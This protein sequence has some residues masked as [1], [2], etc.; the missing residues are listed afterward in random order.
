MPRSTHVWHVEEAVPQV[1]Q[2]ASRLDAMSKLPSHRRRRVRPIPPPPR[3]SSLRKT[4]SKQ[5]AAIHATIVL[6]E[7]VASYD[8]HDSCES[9]PMPSPKLLR[10]D[11]NKPLPPTPIDQGYECSAAEYINKP[12]P[13]TPIERDRGLSAARIHAD[14]SYVANAPPPSP[15]EGE[16]E[17]QCI[18]ARYISRRKCRRSIKARRYVPLPGIPE[19]A[20]EYEDVIGYPRKAT[21]QPRRRLSATTVASALTNVTVQIKKHLLRTVDSDPSF[22]CI[23][24]R[25]IER[26]GE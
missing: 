14:F 21:E 11:L 18:L 15:T 9:K 1:P 7:Y 12:L 6:A 26:L 20:S 17:Q 10:P 13:P 3:D 25:S 24:A 16:G 23:D 4:T 5:K 22:T 2:Q 19:D 8:S